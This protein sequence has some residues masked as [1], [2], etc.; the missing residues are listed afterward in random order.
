MRLL[1]V[2]RF[3][4][5]AL[6][7]GVGCGRAAPG[8]AATPPGRGPAGTARPVA[9]GESV[10]AATTRLARAGYRCERLGDADRRAEADAAF[11]CARWAA[12]R[13]AVTRERVVVQVRADRVTGYAREASTVG[14][15]AA[16]R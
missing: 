12:E 5:L 11:A 8:S 14:Q 10:A 9:I 13:W 16:D 4:G 6:L 15:P 3:V 1:V 7:V 2:H